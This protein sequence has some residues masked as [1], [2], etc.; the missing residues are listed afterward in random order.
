MA[1]LSVQRSARFESL[2]LVLTV[3]RMSRDG[4][5]SGDAQGWS[6]VGRL[7]HKDAAR[8]VHGDDSLSF[9][10]SDIGVFK[11]ILL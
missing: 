9:Q 10:R 1:N 2:D 11:G 5:G 7:S 8:A 4:T 6:E 3:T